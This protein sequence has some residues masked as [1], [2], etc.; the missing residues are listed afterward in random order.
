MSDTPHRLRRLVVSRPA[1][2]DLFREDVSI[3][4]GVPSDAEV[5]QVYTDAE[6]D[7]I[8]IIISHPSFDLVEGGAVIPRADVVA[9]I[10]DVQAPPD[11]GGGLDE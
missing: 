9:E 1:L 4:N 5:E 11:S 2:V 3:I 8:E 7:R 6:R 10:D